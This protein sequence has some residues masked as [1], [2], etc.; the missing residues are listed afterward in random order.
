[1]KE[2]EG[3]KLLAKWMTRIGIVSM[4]IYWLQ[5]SGILK[6]WQPSETLVRTVIIGAFFGLFAVRCLT[7][8]NIYINDF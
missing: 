6:D 3:S 4:V 1:M 2:T 7:P 5:N 8:R